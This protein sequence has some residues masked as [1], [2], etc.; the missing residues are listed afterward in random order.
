MNRGAWKARQRGAKPVVD[1][2]AKTRIAKEAEAAL[3]AAVAALPDRPMV[4]LTAPSGDASRFDG[5]GLACVY[6]VTDRAAVAEMFQSMLDWWSGEVIHA[7]PD[8]LMTAALREGVASIRHLPIAELARGLGASTADL[9]KTVQARRPGTVDEI[10]QHTLA[11]A[12]SAIAIFSKFNEANQH[13][14]E[15]GTADA[16]GSPQPAPMP[17][18]QTWPKGNTKETLVADLLERPQSEHRD[19]II[20]MA[21]RGVFHD[22]E[23]DCPTPKALLID[24]L[25]RFGFPDLAGKAR[26]GG[27]DD[28]PMTVVQ[29][30]ELRASVGPQV[31]DALIPPKGRG[32]S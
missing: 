9:L 3:A 8:R 12:V 1:P 10:T 23:S 14:P 16:S 6:N 2:E 5:A 32:V 26:D 24:V 28:E 21:R 13:Q 31:F 4:L 18:R 17:P 19:Q 30:E 20:E 25:S 27:Y 7:H 29:S 22:H 11:I 15:G